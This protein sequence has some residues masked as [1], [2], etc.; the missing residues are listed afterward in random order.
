[1]QNKILSNIDSL[2]GDENSHFLLA[3][4]GGVDNIV[5]IKI[6]KKNHDS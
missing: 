2:I 1:M 6:K 3:V 4:S 5:I